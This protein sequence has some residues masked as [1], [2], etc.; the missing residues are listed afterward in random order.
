LSYFLSAAGIFAVDAARR[1]IVQLDAVKRSRRNHPVLGPG[2]RVFFA[3]PW[4]TAST[5]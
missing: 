3:K 2:W 5:D 4:A 1:A